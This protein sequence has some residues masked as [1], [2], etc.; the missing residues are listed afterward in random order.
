MRKKHPP[1]PPP[2]RHPA[3]PLALSPARRSHRRP[4]PAP[5]THFPDSPLGTTSRPLELGERGGPGVYLC[6]SLS[7]EF[8]PFQYGASASSA[9]SASAGKKKKR[10]EKKTTLAPDGACLT[11]ARSCHWLAEAMTSAYRSPPPRCCGNCSSIPS[12]AKVNTLSVL[13]METTKTRRHS[14]RCVTESEMRCLCLF[15]DFCTGHDGSC[16]RLHNTTRN[17]FSPVLYCCDSMPR[18]LSL[19]FK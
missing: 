19:D 5:P 3:R 17:N 16:M 8:C 11:A 18:H 12:P 10:K 15:V 7:P 2:S 6:H 13:H 1:P 4:P 9:R 14:E